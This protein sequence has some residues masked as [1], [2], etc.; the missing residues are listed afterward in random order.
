[1]AQECAATGK[2]TTLDPTRLAESM[3][4]LELVG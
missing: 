3:G 4:H 2:Y 1:M